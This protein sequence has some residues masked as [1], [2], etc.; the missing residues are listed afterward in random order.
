[1]KK[2]EH[3]LG[4]TPKTRYPQSQAPGENDVYWICVLEKYQ[5]P[6]FYQKKHFSYVVLCILKPNPTKKNSGVKVT[7]GTI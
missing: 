3:I 4:K 6:D 7:D 2:G 1:M 5:N